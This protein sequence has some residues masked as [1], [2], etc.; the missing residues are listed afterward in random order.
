MRLMEKFELL[1]WVLMVGLWSLPPGDILQDTS[2]P[3]LMNSKSGGHWGVN[4]LI[5]PHECGFTSLNQM[6]KG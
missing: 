5:P 4:S 6:K 1:V 2:I 3:V